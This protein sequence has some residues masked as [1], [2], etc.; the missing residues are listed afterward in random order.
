MTNRFWV[1]MS[2]CFLGVFIG[3]LGVMLESVGY[4][5]LGQ[6]VLMGGAAIVILGAL[7]LAALDIKR[8]L[9]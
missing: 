7:S 2:F 3:M 5:Q 6:I 8:W 4:V 1:L 9:A